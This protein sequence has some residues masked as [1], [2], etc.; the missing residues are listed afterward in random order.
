MG[1]R[2]IPQPRGDGQEASKSPRVGEGQPGGL[3]SYKALWSQKSFMFA[4]SLYDFFSFS[5]SI[6]PYPFV[7]LFSV[8]IFKT[9]FLCL[10]LFL[11]I[12]PFLVLIPP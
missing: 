4:L 2:P 1:F 9:I 12:S 5:L 11:L 3:G 8:V 6:S 10:S 7:T